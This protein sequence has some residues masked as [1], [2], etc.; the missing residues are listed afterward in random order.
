MRNTANGKSQSSAR[1]QRD[2]N[3]K[4][5]LLRTDKNLSNKL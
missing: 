2:Q 5:E 4:T 3:A 1:M